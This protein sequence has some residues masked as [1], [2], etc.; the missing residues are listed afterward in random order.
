MG[1]YASYLLETVVMLAVVC[2]L[3]FA[4]LAFARRMGLG[5]AHGP[6]QLVGQLPLDARRGLYLVKVGAKVFL[7]GA[8]E[9]GLARLGEVDAADLP[10]PP[11]AHD[12]SF[13]EAL[14]RALGRRATGEE[15]PPGAPSS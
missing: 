9:G 6:I 15:P 2:G 7:V 10:D 11:R 13:R 5:R 4:V 1:P 12:T 8:G 3:A 14:A